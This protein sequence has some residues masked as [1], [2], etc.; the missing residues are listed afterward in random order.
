MVLLRAAQAS[1]LGA[2]L[3]DG[4]TWRA[5]LPVAMV[6]LAEVFIRVFDAGLTT[7]TRS[8]YPTSPDRITPV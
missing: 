8:Q 7:F 1:T 4:L 3:N 2:V 5:A 6:A